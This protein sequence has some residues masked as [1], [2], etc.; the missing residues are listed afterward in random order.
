MLREIHKEDIFFFLFCEN[1][2]K[3]KKIV[4]ILHENSRSKEITKRNKSEKH[5]TTMAKPFYFIIQSWMLEEM[6]LSLGEAAVY[7][8]ID[9]LTTSE[10]LEKKGWYGS[11]R[12]LATVLHTSPS[13]MNDILNRL[14]NK[15]Y[16]HFYKDHIVSTIHRK[17]APQTPNVRNPDIILDENGSD[18]P[19]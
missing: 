16:I 5:N 6:E 1:P 7:A 13:T 11:K 18:M 2:C 15:G 12:R 9:G 10:G 17:E 14:E 8:Y 3:Y 19:S 4:V